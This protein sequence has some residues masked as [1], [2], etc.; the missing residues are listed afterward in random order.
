MSGFSSG[1]ACFMPFSALNSLGEVTEQP[2]LGRRLSAA[3]NGGIGSSDSLFKR[4]RQ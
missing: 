4:T 3:P 2:T 1:A